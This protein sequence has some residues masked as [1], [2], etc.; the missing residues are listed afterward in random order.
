MLT[1]G[2][3]QRWWFLPLPNLVLWIPPS[4]SL[5]HLSTF[6]LSLLLSSQASKQVFKLNTFNYPLFLFQ[7]RCTRSLRLS[8]STVPSFSISKTLLSPSVCYTPLLTHSKHCWLYFQDVTCHLIMCHVQSSHSDTSLLLHFSLHFYLYHI[9]HIYKE[10]P[11]SFFKHMS[12][13]MQSLCLTSALI[14]LEP[15]FFRHLK[16]YCDRVISFSPHPGRVDLLVKFLKTQDYIW[17]VNRSNY[18]G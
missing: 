17:W 13:T 5:S 2:G 11:E 4:L 18:P 6:F 14:E 10:Q 7:G 16:C 9:S 12:Q 3:L 15:H 8:L 1:S